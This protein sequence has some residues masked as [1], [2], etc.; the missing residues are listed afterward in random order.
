LRALTTTM[1]ETK[2]AFFLIGPPPYRNCAITSA[3]RVLAARG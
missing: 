3:T 1:D 2:T